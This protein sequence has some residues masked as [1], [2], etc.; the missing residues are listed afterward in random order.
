MGLFSLVRAETPVPQNKAGCGRGPPRAD[1]HPGTQSPHLHLS[2]SH[3]PGFS[4]S[5]ERSLAGHGHRPRA[6]RGLFP[7][8]AEGAQAGAVFLL[9]AHRLGGHG[10]VKHVG[11]TLQ[12]RKV[13]SSESQ[14][15]LEQLFS[16][17]RFL[18]ADSGIVM[19][20]RETGLP[21]CLTRRLRSLNRSPRVPW[22]GCHAA[23]GAGRPLQEA[24]AALSGLSVHTAPSWRGR[25]AVTLQG[26]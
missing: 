2:H 25:P 22:V 11:T 21:L 12:Q 7:H 3:G 13:N 6:S 26:R 17:F 4:L 9:A 23:P 20:R 8:P 19:A 14:S 16:H 24:R 10:F 15:L 1:P 5:P 18:K